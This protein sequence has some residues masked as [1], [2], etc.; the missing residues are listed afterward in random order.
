MVISMVD[1]V[2]EGF[3][4]TERIQ[5]AYVEAPVCLDSSE[6]D[7]LSDLNDNNYSYDNLRREIYVESGDSSFAL[8]KDMEVLLEDTSLEEIKEYLKSYFEIKEGE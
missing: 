7:S 8:Y 2:N 3:V 1:V 4:I 6:G 5:N